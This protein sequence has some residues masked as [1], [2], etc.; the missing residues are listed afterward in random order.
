MNKILA[1]TRGIIVFTLAI[2]FIVPGMTKSIFS[3]DWLPLALR[4]RR[5]WANLSLA[6]LGIRL[7]KKGDVAKGGPFIF[8]GNHRSYI[9]PVIALRDIEALPVAKAEVSS[10]PIIG[11]CAKATGVMWVKR[12]SKSSRANTIKAMERVLSNGFSVLVYPEGTT[13]LDPITQNFQ[14]G[15]FKLAANMGIPVIPIAIHYEDQSDA[16]VGDDTFAPHFIRCFSKKHSYV[17]I[18]YGPPI[19]CQNDEDLL[20]K[21]KDWIDSS[22]SEFENMP[23]IHC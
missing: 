23:S 13:H 5:Y 20:K 4:M 2:F 15:A 6:I 17:H 18:N 19:D 1:V 3:K 11:F 21:A 9:D 10:W 22:L 14:K 12:E 8:V 7:I 16:W